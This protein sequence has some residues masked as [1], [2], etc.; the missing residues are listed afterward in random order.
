M[1]I[2]IIIVIIIIMLI[3][4]PILIMLIII[5]MIRSCI[6]PTHPNN[7]SESRHRHRNGS[8]NTPGHKKFAHRMAM[9]RDIS[10]TL[11]ARHHIENMG[12]QL[13]S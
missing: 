1:L 4:M 9:Q 8:R 5:L 6:D 7:G 13:H 11:H 12:S 3:I 10:V 2:I